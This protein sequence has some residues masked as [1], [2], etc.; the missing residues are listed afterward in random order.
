[1]IGGVK[2]RYH[3]VTETQRTHREENWPQAN[4]DRRS[5][6]RRGEEAKDAKKRRR[7]K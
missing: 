4:T 1:V 7:H 6:A 3:R 2:N 5:S